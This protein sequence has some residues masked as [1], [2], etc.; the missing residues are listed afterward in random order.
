VPRSTLNDLTVSTGI[1]GQDSYDAM[2]R[3]FG[4]FAGPVSESCRP[5]ENKVMM[6]LYAP[7]VS[8]GNPAEASLV[9]SESWG[10]P[11][12]PQGRGSWLV[13]VYQLT[14]TRGAGGWRVVRAEL[15]MQ[16]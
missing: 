10:L 3:C 14:L 15:L 11:P 5:F 2:S 13:N 7:V 6:T 8:A 16:T 1:A 4:P 9:V 12:H